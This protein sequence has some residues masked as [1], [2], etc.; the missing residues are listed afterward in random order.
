MH[1]DARKEY[2]N[3]QATTGVKM[4]QA[5]QKGE[6]PD[7]TKSMVEGGKVNEAR[8]IE[9]QIKKWEETRRGHIKKV[10]EENAMNKY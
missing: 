3:W 2:D 10:I 7:P 8:R 4:I 1:F 9:D 6:T 5:Q